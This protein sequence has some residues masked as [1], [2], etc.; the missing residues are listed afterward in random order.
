MLRRAHILAYRT[1]AFD[2]MKTISAHK[3]ANTIIVDVREKEELSKGIIPNSVNIP[4]SK[5]E[6]TL[7]DSTEH[8]FLTN[9]NIPKPDP[10]DKNL[11]FYCAAG[12]RSLKACIIAE[13]HG[14]DA[15]NYV[16][17]FTEW[18]VKSTQ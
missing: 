17:G 3:P 11:L 5:L 15:T 10:Q 4:L 6:Q 13:N 8:E 16:G 2:E 12:V 9:Y 1:I 14:F 7:N 18:S